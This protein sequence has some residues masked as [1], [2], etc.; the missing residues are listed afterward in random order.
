MAQTTFADPGGV[1]CGCAEHF[2]T[3]TALSGDGNTVLIGAP[4]ADR[5]AGAAYVF[6]REGSSWVSQGPPLTASGETSCAGSGGAFGTSVAL[7]R[8]GDDALVGAE[9]DACGVGAAW[10]FTR[11]GATWT[12]QG[13]K[14]AGR[15]AVGFSRQGSAVAVS[16]DGDVALVG[17]R[18]PAETGAIFGVIQNPRF[19]AVAVAIAGPGLVSPPRPDSAR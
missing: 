4:L 19:E 11:S 12:Q 5:G 17:G 14:L 13:G 1:Q 7:S 8:D 6:V 10:V 2:G 15:G 3:S 9:F 16:A 18:A